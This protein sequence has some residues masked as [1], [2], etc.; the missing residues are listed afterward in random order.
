V[1]KL[2]FDEGKACPIF[3][4]EVCRR[5]I[6][7]PHE[8]LVIWRDMNRHEQLAKTRAFYV[9]KGDRCEEIIRASMRDAP[10]DHQDL[11]AHLVEL[12]NNLDVDPKALTALRAKY[13]RT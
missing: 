1:L 7:V 11:G 3:E 12:C 2:L 6:A 13:Q 8:G 4:C 9:H 10:L 5:M